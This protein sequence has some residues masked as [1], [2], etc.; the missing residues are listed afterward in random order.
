MR[1]D[2]GLEEL[3][4]VTNGPRPAGGTMQLWTWGD[5]RPARWDQDAS[6]C[7]HGAAASQGEAPG[8]HTH[9][10]YL[11]I[12]LQKRHKTREVKFF[13]FFYSKRITVALLSFPCPSFEFE[14][15]IQSRAMARKGAGSIHRQVSPAIQG[16]RP[17]DQDVGQS[18]R[19]DEVL[20]RPFSTRGPRVPQKCLII[21]LNF[22]LCILFNH[23]CAQ[24]FSPFSRLS[25]SHRYQL[26]HP[27]SP[28]RHFL[29]QLFSINNLFLLK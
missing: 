2:E 9:N 20:L 21:F 28:E 1:R 4:G 19:K 27:P 18:A 12:I 8:L 13:F 10:L 7:C 22:T 23:I 11:A 5:G 24:S 29:L 17:L 3:A 25:K 14:L 26:S 15:S 16:Q 6:L